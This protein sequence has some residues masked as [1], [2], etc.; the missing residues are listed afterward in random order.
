MNLTSC[1]Y[2]MLCWYQIYWRVMLFLFLIFLFLCSFC[3][4]YAKDQ[5]K[6]YNWGLSTMFM[7]LDLVKK[8]THWDGFCQSSFIW[9][10]LFIYL[11]YFFNRIKWDSIRFLYWSYLSAHNSLLANSRLQ[12]FLSVAVFLFNLPWIVYYLLRSCTLS[13]ILQFSSVF[14]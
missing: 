14:H 6:H 12:N 3:T 4:Y 8:H 9:N 2:L 1:F 5:L 7:F 13:S 11:F 10:S